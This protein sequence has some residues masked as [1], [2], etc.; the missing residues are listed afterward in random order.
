MIAWQPPEIG[1]A[2]RVEIE[3]IE[4]AA[5]ASGEALLVVGTHAVIQH[6]VRFARLALAIVDEQHRFGVAQRAELRGKAP[7]A[8][9]FVISAG[10]DIVGQQSLETVSGAGSLEPEDRIV[11]EHQQALGA[12]GMDVRVGQREGEVHG[13]SSGRRPTKSSHTAAGCSSSSHSPASGSM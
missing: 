12:Q 7:A 1:S 11:P 4:L 10:V 2:T 8:K 9:L 5:A 6:D 13:S 3:I